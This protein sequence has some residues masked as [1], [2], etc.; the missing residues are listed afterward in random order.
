MR[1]FTLPAIAL[2]LSGTASAMKIPE[3]LAE[4][5]YIA[6][7]DEFGNQD[8]TRLPDGPVTPGLDDLVAGRSANLKKR[9]TNWPSN[10]QPRC[11]GNWTPQNDFWNVSHRSF[12]N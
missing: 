1:F 8:F 11:G 10:T 7:M 6:S 4:G 5:V 12:Y 9:V 2:A 3:G